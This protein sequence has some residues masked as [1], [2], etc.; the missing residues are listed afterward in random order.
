MNIEQQL[1]NIERTLGIAPLLSGTVEDRLE[2][3]ARVIE[4]GVIA[5]TQEFSVLEYELGLRNEGKPAVERVKEV[6]HIVTH[7]LLSNSR[8]QLRRR[9]SEQGREVF[10]LQEENDALRKGIGGESI[11][12]TKLLIKPLQAAIENY[13]IALKAAARQVKVE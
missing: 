13:E 6:R 11:D 2:Q 8:A 12:V 10:R 7:R 4:G 9:I 3:I 5:Q 1:E